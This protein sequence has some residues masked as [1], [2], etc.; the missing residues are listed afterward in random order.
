MTEPHINYGVHQS[1]GVSHVGNQAVGPG[2][3]INASPV[4]WALLDDAL[5]KHAEQL[6]PEAQSATLAVREA[7]TTGAG[8]EVLKHRLD[9][10]ALLAAPVPAV[11]EAVNAVR[12]A[13]GG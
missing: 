10:L 6:P 3:S 8:S 5:D 4:T 2:A 12:Q 11:V 7:R 13:F 9:Q 1:G